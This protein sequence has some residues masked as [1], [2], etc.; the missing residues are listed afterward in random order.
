MAPGESGCRRTH[1]GT[2]RRPSARV[3]AAELE[4]NIEDFVIE[5]LIPAKTKLK[6][7]KV[8]TTETDRFGANDMDPQERR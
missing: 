5:P 3:R 1:R 6:G 4:A 8:K 7:S 2:D